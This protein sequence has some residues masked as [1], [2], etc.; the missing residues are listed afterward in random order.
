ML[1]YLLCLKYL[2]PTNIL[3]QGKV[4]VK[5]SVKN[6]NKSML[7]WKMKLKM[8]MTEQ[9]ILIKN[10]QDWFR[11]PCVRI[12]YF[13]RK[14]QSLALHKCYV[15]I[16]YVNIFYMAVKFEIWKTIFG[17]FGEGGTVKI[18]SCSKLYVFF[19][20]PKKTKKCTRTRLD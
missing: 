6:T 4:I 17:P 18:L 19:A 20:L 12:I 9:L 7:L 11:T 3:C 16:F 15:S 10:T 8:N 14:D 1:K 13:T 2:G 5:L